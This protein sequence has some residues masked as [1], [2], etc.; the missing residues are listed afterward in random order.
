MAEENYQKMEKLKT[1]AEAADRAKSNFLATMSHELRTPMNGVLGMLNILKDTDL[2]AQQA[3][4]ARTASS[5]A[6]T[7]ITLVNDILDL[8]KV[9]S[10]YSSIPAFSR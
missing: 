8:A 3:E 1:E 2:D 6:N 5:C 7:L 4:Y 9:R 10:S